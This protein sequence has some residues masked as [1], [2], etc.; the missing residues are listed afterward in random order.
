MTNDWKND[1]A[2]I[3]KDVT[4]KPVAME[5]HVDFGRQIQ[6]SIISVI[7][8][9]WDDEGLAISTD[10]RQLLMEIREKLPKT[11]FVAYIGTTNW[12]IEDAPDGVE[13]C[14]AR[15]ESQFDIL[16]LAF[17]YYFEIGEDDDESRE[18]I[19][20]L[21]ELEKDYPFDIQHVETDT[22]TMHFAQPIA[23]YQDLAERLMEI[24]PDLTQCEI[25][26]VEDL[27][28]Y[29]EQGSEVA[30]WFD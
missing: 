14:I 15:G 19:E 11:G 6:D 10:P 21:I 25:N 3:L 27:K 24:C 8:D 29:L 16:R 7:V 17:G 1:L 22:I 9:G 23:N 30:L 5:G 13:L 12:L 20:S 28:V 18:T 4:G 2:K 26:T